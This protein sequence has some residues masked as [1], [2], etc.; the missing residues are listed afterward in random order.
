MFP[1]L[2][3]LV[4]GAALVWWRPAE[5]YMPTISFSHP[6]QYTNGVPLSLTSILGTAV[7]YGTCAGP[8]FG[9]KIHSFEIV[10]SQMWAT[11]PNVQ[12]GVY[13]YRLATR[14]AAG[15]SAWSVVVRLVV[16]ASTCG[17]GCHE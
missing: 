10:G 11:A 5:A 14:T 6:T 2:I 15:L 9:A 8:D 4:L 12:P 7:E 3:L 17:S 1:W 16:P 13:C